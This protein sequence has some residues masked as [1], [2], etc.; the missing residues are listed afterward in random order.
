MLRSERSYG[1]KLA[2]FRIIARKIMKSKCG[3]EKMIATKTYGLV[4]PDPYVMNKLNSLKNLDLKRILDL[5][6]GQ[7][8]HALLLSKE[9]FQTFGLDVSPTAVAT[10]KT[11]LEECGLPGTI[12]AGD[13]RKIEYPDNFFDAILA[14]RVIYLGQKDTVKKS[15]SEI[16]R[17]LRPGGVVYASIRS[18]NNTLYHVGKDKG[19]EIEQNTFLLNC[20]GLSGIVYHFF[21]KEEVISYLSDFDILEIEELELQ[22][23]EYT[24]RYPEHKN[25]FWVVMAKKILKR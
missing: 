8:R 24:A 15:F 11:V 14:W 19:E 1:T 18:T 2:L 3:W 6:C 17:V 4:Q 22:H 5:G 9:N 23:T 7:G 20:D 13:M 16:T 12:K 21:T 10:T 25:L